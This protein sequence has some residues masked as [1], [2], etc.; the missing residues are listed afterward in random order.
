M[1][2][3]KYCSDECAQKGWKMKTKQTCQKKYGVD[4]P[5][6]TPQCAT[7]N[8]TKYSKINSKFADLLL[9]NN[10]NYIAEFD[11]L[12]GYFYDFYLPEYNL[13]IEINPTFTH[14]CF[15]TGVYDPRPKTYHYDKTF[16]A[17]T[18]GYNCI[19][20]W[21]WNNWD[22]IINYIQNGFKLEYKGIKIHWSRNNE[23]FIPEDEKINPYLMS[24]GWLPIY[25]DGYE[26]TSL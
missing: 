5:C 11:E 2:N 19:C 12:K 17:L 16:N 18:N 20:V 3:K 8:P 6:F 4:Y 10:I 23:H 15:D 22:D 26:V 25:D 13:L 21:D 7:K 9:N 14:T 24:E 1:K